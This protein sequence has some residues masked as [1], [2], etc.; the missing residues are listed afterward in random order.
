MAK[1]HSGEEILPNVS[2]RWVGRTTVTDDRQTTDGFAIAKTKDPNVTQTR[3]GKNEWN[4]KGQE[5][6]ESSQKVREVS[7]IDR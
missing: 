7:P 6:T 1:V 3:S 5:T 2:T 4:R